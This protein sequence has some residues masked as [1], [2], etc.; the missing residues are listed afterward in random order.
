VEGFER[1]RARLTGKTLEL[2]WSDEATPH[3]LPRG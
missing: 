3:V 2:L 1:L